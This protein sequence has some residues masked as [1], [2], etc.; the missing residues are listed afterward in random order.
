MWNLLS[1]RKFWQFTWSMHD[2][3]ELVFRMIMGISVRPQLG[4]ILA[5]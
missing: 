3:M 2:D 1:F 4:L 5:P